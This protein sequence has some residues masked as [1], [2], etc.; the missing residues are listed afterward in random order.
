MQA[1]NQTK[2]VTLPLLQHGDNGSAVELL[3]RLLLSFGYL[4]ISVD[5]VFTQ[6]TENYVREFQ[7]SHSLTQDGIVGQQ[8]WQTMMNQIPMIKTK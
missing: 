3:E 2:T 5:G 4:P 8:T 7:Q 6:Q 1:Q